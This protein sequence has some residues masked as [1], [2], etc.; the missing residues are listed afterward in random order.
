MEQRYL[1]QTDIEKTKELFEYEMTEVILMLKGEFATVSGKDMDYSRHHVSE[2]KRKAVL[3][4][5]DRAEIPP[6]QMQSLRI[7]QELTGKLAGPVY[8]ASKL[9]GS[10]GSG[11]VCD[12]TVTR[13]SITVPNIQPCR[14]P[15]S[16]PQVQVSRL[17]MHQIPAASLPLIS[18]IPSA[19]FEA[20]NISLPQLSP[21]PTVELT[22][23]SVAGRRIDVPSVSRF[24]AQ[25]PDVKNSPVCVD[26]P[27]V[28]KASFSPPAPI[29]PNQSG[30]E[31][32]LL[33]D[34]QVPH[35]PA[36][37][38]PEVNNHFEAV[39]Y[40]MVPKF[41]FSDP[42]PIAH[43]IA[44]PVTVSEEI[45][46]KD[47]IT[48]KL[49]DVCNTH[50][51]KITL[52]ES[53]QVIPPVPVTVNINPVCSGIA[54]VAVDSS[55]NISLPSIP[56]YRDPITISPVQILPTSDTPIPRELDIMSRLRKKAT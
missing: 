43:G 32:G 14:I 7:S 35:L 8:S 42:Q 29:Q 24:R 55:Q 2:E 11:E 40:P 10:D 34:I 54:E 52:T 46:N 39:P 21:F 22:D 15:G 3:S 25:I 20:E 36:V 41:T 48:A 51:S 44:I 47:A 28:Q 56:H 19:S 31:V 16:I 38:I 13:P 23:V 33:P 4:L 17:H 53:V 37:E 50:I 45:S 12:L 18:E 27:N 30:A 5:I 49:M 6:V 9:S 26:I 1:K